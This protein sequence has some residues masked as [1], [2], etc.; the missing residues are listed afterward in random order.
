MVRYSL[1]S[2]LTE[3]LELGPTI[4]QLL[5]QNNKYARQAKND[6]PTYKKVLID[7][8]H[9]NQLLLFWKSKKIQLYKYTGYMPIYLY[10]YIYIHT[11]AH[12]YKP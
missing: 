1:Y 10:V 7:G 4:N 6:V 5:L 9:R 8:L 11:L 2:G 12:I 3:G